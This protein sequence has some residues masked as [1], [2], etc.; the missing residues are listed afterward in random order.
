[1]SKV[2]EE[3][4]GELIAF[5]PFLGE[6]NALAFLRAAE[7]HEWFRSN[8]RRQYLVRVAEAHEIAGLTAFEKAKAANG[9]GLRVVAAGRSV[10]PRQMI[11]ERPFPGQLAGRPYPVVPNVALLPDADENAFAHIRCHWSDPDSVNFREREADLARKR[12]ARV[13]QQQLGFK[14]KVEVKRSKLRPP[15]D[16]HLPELLREGCYEVLAVGAEAIASLAVTTPLTGRINSPFDNIPRGEP[17]APSPQ[18]APVESSGAPTS[19]K[20]RAP[21]AQG[22]DDR[23][24]MPPGAA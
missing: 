4:A 14:A 7:D 2:L 18:N 12:E 22:P 10:E 5:W 13:G 20:L 19:G 11:I 16:A 15:W 3:K 24:T 17:L 6:R 8:P 21:W 23:P 1:M 9:A